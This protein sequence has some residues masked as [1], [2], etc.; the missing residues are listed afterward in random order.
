MLLQRVIRFWALNLVLNSL[1]R[2]N[3]WGWLKEI[4]AINIALESCGT[5]AIVAVDSFLMGR[6]ICKKV[7]LVVKNVVHCVSLLL[8]KR[9]RAK[10]QIIKTLVQRLVPSCFGHN[11]NF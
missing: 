7:K 5:V 1:V 6:I 3:L 8:G 4:C 2:L 10:G 11:L 9:D